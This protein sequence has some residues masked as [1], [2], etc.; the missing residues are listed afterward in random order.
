MDIFKKMSKSSNKLLLLIL[1]FSLLVRFWRLNYPTNFY[2]DEVYHAFTA[3]E[4][5]RSNKAAWEWWNTPPKGFAYEWTH[6]PLAK[7][8]MATGI[9]L[10]GENAFG[11]RFFGALLGVGCIL[12]VYLLGKEL[13]GQKVALFASFLF[14]FDG[15][16]LVMSRIGM[17]DIYFLFFALLALYLFLK[18]KLL[19]SGITFGLSLASKWTAVYL[20]PIFLF[21]W[22]IQLIK[23][24]RK[25]RFNKLNKLKHLLILYAL[26]FILIPLLIYLVS[27]LPFFT[28]GHDLSTWWGL[29]K[30]MWWYHTK[31]SATHPYASPWWS[32]PIMKTP[33]WLFVDY[34]ENAIANIY[35]M[36]NPIVWWGGLVALPFVSWQAI[37]KKDKKLGL[38]VFAYF[39]FFLP[40]AISPRIMFIYHYLPSIPF[41]CLF[42]GWILWRLWDKR[43][44]IKLGVIGY[45]VLV[46]LIFLLFYPR[47]TAIYAK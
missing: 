33:V 46:V 17:N 5:V 34:A 4:M 19:F 11:W 13:F 2:F 30:Q 7:L 6:P 21:W 32:W 40:W 8:G 1:L 41:L 3:Q 28:S 47:W 39:A 43:L 25:E 24:K 22:A 10:F 15:L 9:I 45:L 14:A 12:L 23:L 36:G 37:K 42:L 29:Q 38:I 35:A 18:G 44:E 20:L 31:L 27:Y 26:Y 16:P